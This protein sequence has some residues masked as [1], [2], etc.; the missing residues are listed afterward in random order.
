MNFL[1][2][3]QIVDYCCLLSNPTKLQMLICH[4]RNTM[5]FP[6]RPEICFA[7]I[8]GAAVCACAEQLEN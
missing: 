6:V 3:I 8:N 1:L 5:S 2:E 7:C 4:Y